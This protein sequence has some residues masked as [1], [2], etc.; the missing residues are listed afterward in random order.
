MTSGE[1]KAVLEDFLNDM[2]YEEKAD[3]TIKQYRRS[4][5]N[6]LSYIN[7]E[8]KEIK[9]DD[10]MAYKKKMLESYK[11]STINVSIICIN[12]FLR[13][14][15]TCSLERGAKS[16]LEVKTIR[17]Q[18]VSSL[19]DVLEP[20]EL[21]RL[22]KYSRRMGYDDIY[23]IIKIFAY[24]GIRCQELKDFTAENMKHTIIRTNSKGKV[25]EIIL[26]DDLKKEINQY[27]QRHN[28]KHGY[29]FRGNK[30]DE[31][32]PYQT[33]YR[34]LQ[35]VAGAAKINK[36]KVHPHSFRHLFGIVFMQQGGNIDELA[37]IYGHAS[38]ETTRIYLRTTAKMKKEKMSRLKY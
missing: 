13:Y 12:K 18:R 10:V 37:D 35:K 29:I 20:A 30:D 33:I 6:F 4:C 19:E 9:K 38:L 11:P 31:L 8:E 3:N 22:L 2:K 26:R 5:T 28:I 15:D 25:R 27:M 32:I 36:K 1:M 16:K 14:C 7:D 23:L 24:T 17:E 34:K 21:K